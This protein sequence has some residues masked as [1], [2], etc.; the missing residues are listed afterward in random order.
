MT[1]AALQQNRRIQG[2]D[3]AP[4]GGIRTS[5]A[6]PKF[7]VD[8]FLD[9]VTLRFNH[10]FLETLQ[11]CFSELPE[12]DDQGIKNLI[13]HMTNVCNNRHNRPSDCIL[14][15]AEYQ[16]SMLNGIYCVSTSQR[17]ALAFA[18]YLATADYVMPSA[19]F[20]AKKHLEG[21]SRVVVR[22]APPREAFYFNHRSRAY[23][24]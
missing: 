20:A 4:N 6:A 16:F 2:L 18:A 8:R 14:V 22:Y 1:Y 9:S 23:G 17:F 21:Q 24:E 13:E 3:G 5:V 12:P 15:D 11:Q 7:Q 10:Q 19:V